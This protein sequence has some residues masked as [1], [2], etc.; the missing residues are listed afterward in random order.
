[1]SHPKI[2]VLIFSFF[3]LQLER[4]TFSLYPHNHLVETVDVEYDVLTIFLEIPRSEHNRHF[5]HILLYSLI[6]A[7]LVLDRYY[8]NW[9]N[10]LPRWNFHI[11]IVTLLIERVNRNGSCLSVSYL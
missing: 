4:N 11:E 5:Q 1:M 3:K 10:H 7:L 6:C 2:D 9:Q 8:L